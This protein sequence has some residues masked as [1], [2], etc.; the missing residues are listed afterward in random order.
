MTVII[1]HISNNSGIY[2]W[3]C[4]HSCNDLHADPRKIRTFRKFLHYV[5]FYSLVR[6]FPK[7]Y[8]YRPAFPYFCRFSGRPKIQQLTSRWNIKSHVGGLEISGNK[9]LGITSYRTLV[10]VLYFNLCQSELESLNSP[11]SHIICTQLLLLPPLRV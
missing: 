2:Y 11:D 5:S 10:L 1:I 9:K 7:L 8:K 6:S 4:H 3:Y